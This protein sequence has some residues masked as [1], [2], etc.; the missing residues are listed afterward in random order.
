MAEE[1]KSPW[2]WLGCGCVGILG[3]GLAVIAALL[4]F[5]FQTART[6]SDPV[7]LKEEAL[8]IMSADAIPA[9]YQ[10]KMAMKV[11][12]Y[13]ELVRL[14]GVDGDERQFI[15]L[16]G[17]R[18]KADL[19]K[20][21]ADD[22]SFDRELRRA[23]LQLEHQQKILARDTL[24]IGAAEV[25][26]VL[27]DGDI[28]FDFDAKS[29]DRSIFDFNFSDLG[30]NAVNESAESQRGAAILIRCSEGER[31]GLGLW[32]GPRAV[33][34]PGAEAGAEATA[35]D[36]AALVDFIEQFGLCSE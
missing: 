22:D 25:C 18:T 12:L 4:Y 35:A 16:K 36:Q 10:A 27:V 14:E 32:S 5:G 19:K 13:A 2:V 1:S 29:G 3:I 30:D 9:G 28:Q 34:E 31:P 17:L 33:T 26:Y 15:Y 24:R 21:F 7:A 23:G 20:A 6:M 11:P 8:R